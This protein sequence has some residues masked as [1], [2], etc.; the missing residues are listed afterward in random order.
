MFVRKKRASA[1]RRKPKGKAKA[2]SRMPRLHLPDH[3]LRAAV[4]F[5][6]GIEMFL[7]FRCDSQGTHRPDDHS[8]A[9][10]LEL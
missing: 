5:D 8:I 6:R 2:K 3:V 10:V 4:A 1:A 7:R 9:H